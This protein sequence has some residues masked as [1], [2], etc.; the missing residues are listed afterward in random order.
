MNLSMD[1]RQQIMYVYVRIFI[2]VNQQMNLSHYIHTMYALQQTI[3][4]T[5]EWMYTIKNN[6]NCQKTTKH[7]QWKP[8]PHGYNDLLYL[9]D[10]KTGFLSL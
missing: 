7:A 8:D 5:I 9:S 4:T 1:V 6:K 2:A 10:C 3:Q